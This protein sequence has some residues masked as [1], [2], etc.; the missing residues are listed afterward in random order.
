MGMLHGD[1]KILIKNHLFKGLGEE[2]ISDIL[3]CL[4]SVEKTYDKGEIIILSGSKITSLGIVLKGTI[5]IVRED[6][7]GNRM[8]V[9]TLSKGEIFAETIAAQNMEA[10][11]V[12]VYASEFVK[13]LWISIKRIANPCR[14]VC[15]QHS[16]I[17][18]NLLELIAKK[19]MYLNQ[20][21]ELLSQ[22]SIRDKIML[23]LQLEGKSAGSNRFTI[24]LNR[25]ELADYLCVDR[26]ALSRELGKLQAAGE[27][28]FH[29]NEF[30]IM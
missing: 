16:N 20:R 18:M 21:M 14:E 17:V 30:G 10:S 15:S 2:K 4:D 23:Y 19:N 25:N 7:S 9:A 13:V 5:Q 12:S 26:S 3:Q 8:M 22:R 6:V 1:K 11:P 27:I 28:E 29:K 24:R